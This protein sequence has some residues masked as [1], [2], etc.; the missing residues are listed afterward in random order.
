MT[1]NYP[2]PAPSYYQIQAQ[3]N[4]QKLETKQSVVNSIGMFLAIAEGYLIRNGIKIRP[5][6]AHYD[7]FNVTSE[8]PELIRLKLMNNYMAFSAQKQNYLNKFHT[9]DFYPDNF[10]AEQIKNTIQNWIPYAS[11]IGEQE[12]FINIL[13]IFGD[14]N[15]ISNN[16]NKNTYYKDIQGY[17]DTNPKP[18]IT[19]DPRDQAKAI[20]NIQTQKAEEN[21]RNKEKLENTGKCEINLILNGKAGTS[22]LSE[23]MRPITNKNP[24]Q[25]QEDINAINTMKDMTLKLI[26]SAK[27]LNICKKKERNQKRIGLNTEIEN[28]KINIKIFKTKF[29]SLDPLWDKI[30]YENEIK[31]PMKKLMEDCKS[32]ED[33][34][35][36][37]KID[38]LY[39]PEL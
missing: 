18:N 34:K 2:P 36:F 26:A 28:M 21:R 8:R 19:I 24:K 4:L 37:Q 25:I 35:L 27:G 1:D 38:S 5:L 13:N 16:Q 22:S 15:S 7:H 17:K 33:Y 32:D 20:A 3:L 12:L 11:Q 30:K 23:K 14:D 39:N 29:G 9:Y 31:N 10:S 6:F